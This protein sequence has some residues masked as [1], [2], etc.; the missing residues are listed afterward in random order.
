[1]LYFTYSAM[2]DPV[3]LSSVAPNAKFLHIAHLPEAKLI[4]PTADGRP[5]IRLANGNTVCGA[6][7]EVSAKETAAVEK[8]EAA[9][10]RAPRRDLRA[11]DRAGNKYE[12][13]TFCHTGPE[14]E[15]NPDSKYMEQVVRGARHWSLP[16]GWVA[17]LEDLGEDALI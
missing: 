3:L 10:G 13:V 5:S 14:G 1:M 4:F 16:A 11:V 9:E 15:F 6:V 17:G 12:V 8:A 7:F 2:L